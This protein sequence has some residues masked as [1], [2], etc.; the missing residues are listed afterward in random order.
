MLFIFIH[1][2][3]SFLV[4]SY[5]KFKKNYI[6]RYDNNHTAELAALN[7]SKVFVP[8]FGGVIICKNIIYH[9]IGCTC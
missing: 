3:L 1:T 5:L 4:P 7:Q 9:I 2:F 8:I 6:S